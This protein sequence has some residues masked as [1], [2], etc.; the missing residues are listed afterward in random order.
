VGV[1]NSIRL[2]IKNP[3]EPKINQMKSRFGILQIKL[4]NIDAAE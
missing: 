4:K 3:E 2:P 1:Y